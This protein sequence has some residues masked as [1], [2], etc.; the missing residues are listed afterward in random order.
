MSQFPEDIERPQ[1]DVVPSASGYAVA[2]PAPQTEYPGGQQTLPAPVIYAAPGL[3]QQ[4]GL[5][6]DPASGL[7]LPQGTQLASAGR[8]IGAFFLAIPLV[9]VTLGIGYLIWGVIAW[10]NGQ[11]PALQVLGMRCWRPETGRVANWGWMAL[12]EIVGRIAENILWLI[13][14]VT[15]FI[16]FLSSKERRSLHD[17]VAGTVV[18]HDPDKV[19]ANKS[20]Q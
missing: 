10:G 13:T 4:P 19:L 20:A 8:R 17:L 3:A 18:L 9:I 15:S 6:F 11:T 14:E 7:N 1:P 5:Y 12:R 16:M 2:A